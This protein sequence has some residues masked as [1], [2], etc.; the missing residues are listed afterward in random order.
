MLFSHTID[1]LS[2]TLPSQDAK[3]LSIKAFLGKVV[4]S[5]KSKGKYGYTNTVKYDTGVQRMYS[6]VRP[7]MGEHF[8]FSGTTLKNIW[9][10]FGISP[11]SLLIVL[12]DFNARVSR[13][14]FAIDVRGLPL[15]PKNLSLLKNDAKRGQGRSPQRSLVTSD[16]GGETHY[17]GSRSSDKFLRIYNK[18]AQLGLDEQW[19]RIELEMKGETAHAVGWQAATLSETE[20]FAMCAGMIRSVFDCEDTTWQQALSGAGNKLDVPKQDKKDTLAWLMSSVAPSIAR[21]ILEN[22]HKDVWGMFCKEIQDN[23]KKQNTPE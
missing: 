10:G 21:V 20:F 17:V 7:D 4:P 23:L 22:P 18:A 13:I 15:S 8:I 11:I 14:D 5:T 2:V 9:E 3:D 16:G 19:T 6:T 1:W 12:I